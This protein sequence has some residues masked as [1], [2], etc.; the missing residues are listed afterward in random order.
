MEGVRRDV[1]Q[2]FFFFFCIF[3]K[4]RR[5]KLVGGVGGIISGNGSG[6]WR[7]RDISEIIFDRST[8]SMLTMKLFGAFFV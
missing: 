8:M 5:K 3:L 6:E 2:L 7:R 1:V 4:F